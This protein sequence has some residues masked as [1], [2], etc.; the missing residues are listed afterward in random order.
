MTR[1]R[2][3]PAAAANDAFARLLAPH[4]DPLPLL[5]IEQEFSICAATGA[6]VDFRDLIHRLSIPGRRVDPGDPNAYRLPWGGALTA[7]GPEAEVATPPI[8]LLPGAPSRAAR[9]ATGTSEVL[10]QLLP[11]GTT[12]HGYSTHLSVSAPEERLPRMASL[13]AST[14]AI[15]LMLL[16]DGRDT[17]GVLIRPRR[18]R[19][20]L[21]LE[22][23][24]GDRL[25]AL[26][27]FA[28]GSVAAVSRAVGEHDLAE[29]PTP[30][31]LSLA[32]AT[33]RFG[34][35]VDRRAAGSD[36]HARGRATELVL[37]PEG[38][39]T[40][41]AHLEAAWDSARRELEACELDDPA[42]RA[43]LE[44]LIRGD[45]PL[46][47]EADVGSGV[48]DPQPVETP[49]VTPFGDLLRPR[50][51]PAFV[52]E[53]AWA[54][55]DHSIFRFVARR[56]TAYAC[57]PR[58]S[59]SRFLRLAD[60]GALDEVVLRYLDATE[61]ARPLL[62]AGQ[63]GE[64][65]LFDVV[66]AGKALLPDEPGLGFTGGGPRRGKRRHRDQRQ[67]HDSGRRETAQPEAPRP[68]KASRWSSKAKVG[69]AVVA[70]LV[71]GGAATAFALAGGDDDTI[72]AVALPT[73]AV[74][75]S[76][77]LEPSASPTDVGPPP[78]GQAHVDGTYAYVGNSGV[79]PPSIAFTSSCDVGP[80]DA[81]AKG[82]TGGSKVPVAF[83]AA[84]GGGA[85]VG[86]DTANPGCPPPP[87]YDPNVPWPVS[88]DFRLRAFDAK[89]VSGVWT[90]TLLSGTVHVQA[91]KVTT[92]AGGTNHICNKANFTADVTYRLKP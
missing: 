44:A 54:T 45:L 40:A 61:G 88:F 50:T 35:Y 2:P 13:Y 51:R 24:A 39:A 83:T 6:P 67:H 87:Q 20:E 33:A 78:I 10:A 66:G 11:A 4:D 55:W 68:P 29:L 91:P 90:A 48:P 7:D 82:L 80:C 73:S 42:A 1:H 22:H 32:P 58:D 70:A 64:P 76:T 46:P 84:F 81:K 27:L 21:C 25:A 60:E 43:T 56:R 85:Y 5:G 23:V 15:A 77:G 18:G 41:Q 31:A 9:D 74:S 37:D 65:G 30:V 62:E 86:S 69:A 63:T 14:F 72:G 38:R 26:I 75:A 92:F 79:I 89:M 59:L 53:A 52:I 28:A 3:A 16:S 17:P 8:E 19:L 12:I 36:L 47:C 34:W 71:I 57:I 49:E